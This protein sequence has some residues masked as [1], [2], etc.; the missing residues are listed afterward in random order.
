MRF[1]HNPS[2]IH[3]W[4]IALCSIVLPT[5][6]HM[7][8]VRFNQLSNSALRIQSFSPHST[9]QSANRLLNQAFDHSM[10]RTSS[11]MNDFKWTL[12][13]SI[14]N[15]CFGYYDDL[16]TGCS[17]NNAKYVFSGWHKTTETL[18]HGFVGL[19]IKPTVGRAFVSAFAGDIFPLFLCCVGWN[20]FARLRSNW[21]V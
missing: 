9:S 21:F 5:P 14:A 13:I 17:P 6:H 8:F 2:S 4:L 10:N 12:R 18:W 19:C 11:Q 16:F 20:R 1:A 15:A 3:D 7:D